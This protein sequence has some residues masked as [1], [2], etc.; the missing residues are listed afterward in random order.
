MC[1]QVALSFYRAG[2]PTTGPQIGITAFAIYQHTI[3]YL[4]KGMG[5]K[6]PKMCRLMVLTNL[7]KQHSLYLG[8]NHTTAISMQPNLTWI[9]M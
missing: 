8:T 1:Q 3:A 7:A 2:K 6:E 9:N 4:H 5:E